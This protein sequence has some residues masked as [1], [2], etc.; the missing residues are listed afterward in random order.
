M[1]NLKELERL[2]FSDNKFF[3]LVSCV[4]IETTVLARNSK[5]YSHTLRQESVSFFSGILGLCWSKDTTDWYVSE[6]KT[7][8]IETYFSKGIL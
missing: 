3:N 7:F 8:F 5:S 6:Q 2:D 4:Y 1:Q